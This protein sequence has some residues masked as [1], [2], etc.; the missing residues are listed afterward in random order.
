MEGLGR[1][2]ARGVEGS[3]EL[4]PGG[5]RWAQE[6]FLPLVV[7]CAASAGAPVPTLAEWAGLAVRA[8]GESSK[9]PFSV[10]WWCCRSQGLG[11]GKW[12]GSRSPAWMECLYNFS[13]LVTSFGVCGNGRFSLEPLNF[14]LKWGRWVFLHSCTDRQLTEVGGSGRITCP[15]P[16]GSCPS[17]ESLLTQRP[18]VTVIV[19]IK[20][21]LGRGPRP[22]GVCQGGEES[23]LQGMR[24]F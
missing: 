13:A 2:Q 6:S 12:E 11:V 1:S 18:R 19:R 17:P 23:S 10:E 22:G 4:A 20:E 3:G 15:V 7:P 14:L 9:W 16:S 21:K 24:S 5:L 8:L